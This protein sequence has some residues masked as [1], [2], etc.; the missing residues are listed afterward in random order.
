MQILATL[1]SKSKNPKFKTS[2]DVMRMRER[3][4]LINK[5]KRDKIFYK[6]YKTHN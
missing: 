5:S 6:R 3:L 2:N 4:S 1:R